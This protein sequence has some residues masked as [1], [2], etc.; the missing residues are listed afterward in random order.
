MGNISTFL[1]LDNFVL[2]A[3]DY[4]RQHGKQKQAELGEIFDLYFNSLSSIGKSKQP[5]EWSDTREEDVIK[6]LTKAAQSL[7]GMYYLSESGFFDLALS[8]K[9][10]YTELVLVTIAIGYDKQSHTDWK[11]NRDN[12][13]DIHEV[14]KRLLTLDTVPLVEKQLI[15]MALKYWDESSQLHSHQISKKAVEEGLSMANGDI[16]LGSRI[17]KEE[18]QIR[19][20]NTLRNMCLNIITI[21]LGVFDY[22]ALTEGGNSAKYPEAKAL[23]S[24]YNAFQREDLKSELTI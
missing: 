16:N 4:F 23:M 7:F 3:R 20:I 1:E 8:L 24:K 19:R 14:A 21:L 17:I 13:R 10:N 18:F 22:V 6:V 12:F 15:P 11:N 2:S 9:R 5:K